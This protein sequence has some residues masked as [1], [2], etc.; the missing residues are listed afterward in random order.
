MTAERVYRLLLRVYPSDFRSEYGREMTLVFRDEYRT[1]DTNAFAFWV[2]MLCDAAQSAISIWA[3]AALARVRH[4]TRTLEA[5]MKLAGV[6]AVLLGLFEAVN[7]LTELVPAMQGTHGGAHFAA[8]VL[9]FVAA[10]LLITAGT[11]LF[12]GTLSGRHGATMALAAS[13]VTIVVARLTH[14]WMSMLSQLVGIA[15]PL[16]LLAAMHW[17]RRI[18]P[19]TSAPS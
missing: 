15:S 7:A 14:P 8:I 6:L 3:H 4:H 1:R 2:D 17:P 18:D 13:L 5:I 10:A 11:A 16:A 9:A 12:R 19:S